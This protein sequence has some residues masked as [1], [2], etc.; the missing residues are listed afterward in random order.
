[1]ISIRGFIFD[2]DGVL[3]DTAE[4]HYRGWKRLVDEEGLPFTREDNEHLRGIP[5]R[6]SLLMILK[7]RTYPEEK[8]QEMM[9]RKNNYYLEFIREITPADL[10]PGAREL[11]DEIHQA[12]LKSALG[13]ASK[14]APD[15]IRRLGIA[16]LLD[17]V[18]HGGSVTKQK[19]A[20]DLFLHAAGQLGL[21]PQ[22]CVV[23][24]DAAAGIEAGRTGGFH[25]LGLGPR[26]R[27]GNADAV[28]DS[29]ANVRLNQI[30]A[31]LS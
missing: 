14:N 18:S 7:G 30:L 23:V 8:I 17:A 25:T 6:E 16:D 19:P 12:G 29:L 26:E 5:R 27:V 10:L 31:L 4:Y 20:P 11:L 21:Q 3:T 22:E 1:V 9:E 13:S 28:L 2:L 24:E 15:V